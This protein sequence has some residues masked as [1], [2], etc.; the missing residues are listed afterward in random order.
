VTA[1]RKSEI[2][3]SYGKDIHFNSRLK[4]I[5]YQTQVEKVFTNTKMRLTILAKKIKIMSRRALSEKQKER[6]KICHTP[7]LL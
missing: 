5:H 6:M 1:Y 3:V 2:L 7:T 4:E